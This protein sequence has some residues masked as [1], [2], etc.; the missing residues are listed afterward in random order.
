MIFEIG[1]ELAQVDKSIIFFDLKRGRKYESG[2]VSVF[3]DI[4]A[5]YQKTRLLT[6]FANIC[7]VYIW[8]EIAND[9]NKSSC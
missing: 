2:M 6:S 1:V 5:L 4:N 9:P 7:Y 8:S 3:D